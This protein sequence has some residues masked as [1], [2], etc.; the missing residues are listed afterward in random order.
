C[1]LPLSAGGLPP[2]IKTIVLK[3]A[4]ACQTVIPSGRRN[5]QSEE[6][7]FPS[8]SAS[9]RLKADSSCVGM[10]GWR[11]CAADK[12]EFVLPPREQ[13]AARTP[14]G[15][16]RRY[17]HRITRRP[18]RYDRR[19]QGGGAGAAGVGAARPARRDDRRTGCALRPVP[20][21]ARRAA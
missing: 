12:T 9:R 2:S 15:A 17:V 4:R 16:R 13:Q 21:P 7:A 11:V 8:R 20:R 19:R 5:D 1:L 14:R 10:T 6:S 18:L 3:S